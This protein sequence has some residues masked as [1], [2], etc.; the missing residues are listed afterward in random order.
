MNTK[1][2]GKK[3]IAIIMDGN[4]RWADQRKMPSFA[5]HRAGIDS[6]KKIVTACPALNINYLTVYAFSTEN[7]T[8]Q[9]QEVNFLFD[10]LSKALINELAELKAKKVKLKFLG[11]LSGLEAD[12]QFQLKKA[13]AETDLKETNL[14]LQVAL[15]YGGRREITQASRKLA[16]D[17]A[18]NKIKIEEIDE[19]LFEKYLYEPN[20]PELDLLIRTGGDKRISNYLLWQCAYS[21][22]IFDD[23]LWPDFNENCLANCLNEFESRI[24]RFGK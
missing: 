3:H 18:E 22:L 12:L 21:E 6:L 13:E 2:A 24:R 5:G 10:L 16:S 8:R 20:L 9:K 14:N 15:N 19:A 11:D 1:I 4:R 7:W 17:L 23:T